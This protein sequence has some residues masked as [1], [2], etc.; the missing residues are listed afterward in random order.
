MNEGIRDLMFFWGPHSWK[1]TVVTQ[2]LP[3]TLHNTH[4][5]KKP[6]PRKGMLKIQISIR[7]RIF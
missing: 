6:L 1:K 4:P 2:T 7:N 5:I 3:N